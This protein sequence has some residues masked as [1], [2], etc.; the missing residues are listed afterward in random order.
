MYWPQ[1]NVQNENIHSNNSLLT[2]F[3]LGEQDSDRASFQIGE[4]D[5]IQLITK[6]RLR[7]ASG[8][9]Q[10]NIKSVTYILLYFKM[11]AVNRNK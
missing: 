3:N 8:P 7:H 9:A 5:F 11:N 2:I 4:S 10:H 1:T 6:G